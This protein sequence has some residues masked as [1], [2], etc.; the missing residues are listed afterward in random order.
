MGVGPCVS[1]VFVTH[2]MFVLIVCV[3]EE[4][5]SRNPAIYLFSQ[6]TTHATLL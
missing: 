2:G 1:F 5:M 3:W 6:I 4:Y